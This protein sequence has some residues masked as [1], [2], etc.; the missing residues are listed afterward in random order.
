MTTAT[1]WSAIDALPMEERRRVLAGVSHLFHAAVEASAAAEPPRFDFI[2]L[3]AHD[4]STKDMIKDPMEFLGNLM[5]LIVG[6]ND[7]TRNS[8]SGGVV[9]LNRYPERVPQAARR[10]ALIPNMVSEIVR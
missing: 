2:S 9:A 7:T 3:L 5:L 10:P 8:I 4:P 1:S 6:G